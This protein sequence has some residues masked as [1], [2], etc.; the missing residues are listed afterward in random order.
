MKSPLATKYHC[1]SRDNKQISIF[2][3]YPRSPGFKKRGTSSEAAAKVRKPNETHKRILELL[4]QKP[5]TADEIADL[6][7]LSV[8]YCRP[9]FSELAS[10]GLICETGER[11]RNESG[12]SASVWMVM[13]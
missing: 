10:K 3:K 7:G 5:S 11:R 6:L 13:P 2:D 12:L 1:A 8:L 9:R 4:R